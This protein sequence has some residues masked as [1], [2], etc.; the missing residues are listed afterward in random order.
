[1]FLGERGERRRRG[2]R[3]LS[4]LHLSEC[5]LSPGAQRVRTERRCQILHNRFCCVTVVHHFHSQT[6]SAAAAQFD[7]GLGETGLEEGGGGGGL[8]RITAYTKQYSLALMSQQI[9]E[10]PPGAKRRLRFKKRGHHTI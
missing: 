3:T 7:S 8:A 1:M 2:A 9:Q 10:R 4:P 5:F 6:V